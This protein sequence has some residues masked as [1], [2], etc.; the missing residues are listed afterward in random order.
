MHLENLVLDFFVIFM[1]QVQPSRPFLQLVDAPLNLR[2]VALSVA[3]QNSDRFYQINDFNLF[4]KFVE[5]ALK[6][7]ICSRLLADTGA[8]GG[9]KALNI[10]N[11]RTENAPMDVLVLADTHFFVDF[12]ADFGGALAVKHAF[13]HTR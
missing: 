4:S 13:Q 8:T 3:L 6:H 12:I 5:A 10:Q 7:A 11:K 1:V 9:C 2:K